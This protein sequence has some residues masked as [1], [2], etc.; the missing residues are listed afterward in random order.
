MVFM[1]WLVIVI[2]VFIVIVFLIKFLTRNNDDDEFDIISQSRS[3][4][5]K[6][7]DCCVKKVKGM[8]GGGA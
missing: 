5:S 4:G 2:V 1:K 7:N 3:L 8:F 6:F